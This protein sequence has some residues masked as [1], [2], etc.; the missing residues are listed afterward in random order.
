MPM[1]QSVQ[2][3]VLFF[4]CAFLSHAPLS[5][6]VTLIHLKVPQMKQK[7]FEDYFSQ[8]KQVR[9]LLMQNCDIN[10]QMTLCD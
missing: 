3:Q 4:L 5:N 2:Q 1:T 8:V 6:Q 7:N 9:I 10:F